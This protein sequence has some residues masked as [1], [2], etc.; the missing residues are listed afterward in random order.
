MASKKL[1]PQSYNHQEPIPPTTM[2]RKDPDLQKVRPGHVC[3][4]P[5]WWGEQEK[6]WHRGCGYPWEDTHLCRTPSS[7]GK[8]KVRRDKIEKMFSLDNTPP[9]TPK[10]VPLLIPEP[11][12]IPYLGKQ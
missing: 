4:D 5:D 9:A 12:S 2:T 7:A 10:S 11:A 6:D 1:G 8:T 3:P